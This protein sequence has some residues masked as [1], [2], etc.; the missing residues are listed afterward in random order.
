MAGWLFF[1][2]LFNPIR[3]PVRYAKC[4]LLLIIILYSIMFVILAR[5]FKILIALVL[6]KSRVSY[7]DEM[8]WV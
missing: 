5:G 3:V 8:K 4:G 1:L 2:Y 7:S 6:K